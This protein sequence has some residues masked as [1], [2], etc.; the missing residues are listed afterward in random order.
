MDS[1]EDQAIDLDPAKEI[2]VGFQQ[3]A[4]EKNQ[5]AANFLIPILQK[6][7]EAYRYLPVAVLEWISEQMSIPTSRIYGVVSFY[8]QFF[9]EPHG[10]YTVRCCRGTAC[11][12]RG[13]NK[14]LDAVQRELDIEDGATSDDLLFSFETVACLGACAL[15]PVMIINDTYHG[16]MT[17]PQVEKVLRQVREEEAK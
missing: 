13:G 17:A 1:S 6:I 10:K 15:A 4:S 9:L 11:H 14:I 7:Q 16:K 12:V 5:D 8:A 3:E 2:L